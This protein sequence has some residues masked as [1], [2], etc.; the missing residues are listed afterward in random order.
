MMEAV[1]SSK[2]YLPTDIYINFNT[3]SSFG[4]KRTTEALKF[5]INNYKID[6]WELREFLSSIKKLKLKL[7]DV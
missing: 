4:L 5:F 1:L 6:S 7:T 2:H 3:N